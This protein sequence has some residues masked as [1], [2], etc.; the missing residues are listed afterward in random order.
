MVRG[1]FRLLRPVL[2]P[3]YMTPAL[4]AE[5]D[6]MKKAQEIRDWAM[7]QRFR[8]VNESTIDQINEEVIQVIRD[9]LASKQK[10]AT[11]T[12]STINGILDLL[13]AIMIV[14]SRT[15]SPELRPLAI[16]TLRKIDELRVAV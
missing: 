10:A 13:K 8:P 11:E 5:F 9:E 16:E 15:C 7:K 1:G 3:A 2:D 6:S 14:K 12:A 4:Q